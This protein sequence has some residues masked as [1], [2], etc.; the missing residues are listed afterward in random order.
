MAFEKISWEELKQIDVEKVIEEMKIEL[1]VSAA[2]LSGVRTAFNTEKYSDTQI[3]FR[4]IIEL[5]EKNM[6]LASMV[7][8]ESLGVANAIKEGLMSIEE[9]LED[10]QIELLDTN[11]RLERLERIAGFLDEN[12]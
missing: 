12:R 4:G 11:T 3:I 10:I 8:F 6:G 2:T 9:S 5:I 7:F 1:R